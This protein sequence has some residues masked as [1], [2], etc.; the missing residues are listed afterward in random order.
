MVIK[1]VTEAETCG[2]KNWQQ[3]EK[4]C[5]YEEMAQQAPGGDEDEI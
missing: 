4:K 2:D 1:K 3:D 5:R